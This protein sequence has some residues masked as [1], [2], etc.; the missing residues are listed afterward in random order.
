[1]CTSNV[2]LSWISQQIAELDR[3]TLLRRR[4]TIDPLA[5]GRCRVE[6]RECWNFAGNDYLDLAHDPRLIAAA[7]TAAA[8]AGTG[9]TASA[10]IVGHTSWHTQLEEKL[11]A[12]EGAEAAILFPTGFAANLGVISSVVGR[13]DAVFSDRLNHASLVDGCRLSRAD[14]TIYDRSRLDELD[15]ALS[16]A[17]SARRRL[18]VSDSLFSMDGD[19]APMAELCDLAESHDAM[20]MVDE[21]HATGIFGDRG[22]GIS[23]QADVEGRVSL[24]VGTLSKAIGAAGGFVT[25]STELINWL[26]NRARTQVYSTALPPPT[27]AAAA[28]AIQIIQEEPQRRELLLERST[29]FR[30]KLRSAGFSTPTAAIGPIVPVLLNDADLVMQVA[31]ELERRGFLVGAIRPPTVPQGTSRLRITLSFAHEDELLDEL[32]SI[33]LEVLRDVRQRTC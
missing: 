16:A 24:R 33:L 23:E 32:L 6:G 22:R 1:M 10:L 5:G 7:Q 20:L 2:A 13:G 21:A 31:A 14:V 9:A 11:A 4:R 3:Q 28:A 29:R 25:G 15:R 30:Q 12:F 19:V 27:C 18:I 17:A 8:D 26:W